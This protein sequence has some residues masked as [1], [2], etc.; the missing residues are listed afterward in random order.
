[1]S[2]TPT[3][4]TVFRLAAL[5][6]GAVLLA[7]SHAVAKEALADLFE[8][9]VRSVVAVEFFVETEIDRRPSVVVG[10]PIDREG[11]VVLL[12]SSVP[13]WLPPAQ[14]KDFK[15]YLPRSVDG[16]PAEYLGQDQLTGWHFIR[17]SAP[18]PGEVVPIT[19]YETA[20]PRIGDPVWGIAV[21]GKDF[22]FQ[23]YLM[24]ANVALLQ[25][26]P[27]EVGFCVREVASP[28]GPVFSA[29]GAF[30][31]WAGNPIWQE[32]DIYLEGVRY[33]ASIRNPNGSGSFLLAHEFLPWLKRIPE[34][35]T[36]QA[37]PWLGIIGMQPVERE[38]AKFLKI[39]N[40]SAILVSDII[41]GSPAAEA[42]MQKRDII[43]TIDGE[44]LPRFSPQRVVS[45]YFEREI[46]RRKPGDRMRLGILRGT[47][48]RLEVEV[49][50]GQQP[51]PLKEA[52]RTWFERLGFTVRE[53]VLYD[54]IQRQLLESG[55][56]GVIAN[57]VKPNTPANTAGLM[58]G[59]LIREIDGVEITDYDQAVEILRG[60]EE[61]PTRNEF[62]L[63]I[64]RGTET[65]VIRVR[66]Q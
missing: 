27:Q 55:E 56:T 46:L 41:E 58:A 25:K 24:E 42:G 21:M 49:T 64:S 33:N 28:G 15:I 8:A 38:A 12:D 63:L 16:V 43:L 14:L 9:R 5:L 44:P 59:D 30:L 57:F 31:G 4:P 1:M 20:R 51:T 65:S 22:D 3:R 61:D 52:R 29:D 23:P 34:S 26:V 50:L 36:G 39:E 19:E 11:T 62:V 13:G 18:F 47:D 66:L 2:S 6:I 32:R 40:V 7:G 60:I 54:K 45:S 10:V 17:A 53:I 35:V 48:E 37:V